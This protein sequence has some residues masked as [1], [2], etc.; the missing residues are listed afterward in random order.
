MLG[1]N[2]YWYVISTNR[3]TAGFVEIAVMIVLHLAYAADYRPVRIIDYVPTDY[4]LPLMR[5]KLKY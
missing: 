4:R 2:T 3:L 1:V 5:A